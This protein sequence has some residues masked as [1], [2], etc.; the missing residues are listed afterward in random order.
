MAYYDDSYRSKLQREQRARYYTPSSKIKE[1]RVASVDVHFDGEAMVLTFPADMQRKQLI[2]TLQFLCTHAPKVDSTGLPSLLELTSSERLH[3]SADGRQCLHVSRREYA[4]I[5]AA[6]LPLYIEPTSKNI[7]REHGYKPTA[8][9]P[10]LMRYNMTRSH[11]AQVDRWRQWAFVR[12]LA[13]LTN[14]T[15]SGAPLLDYEGDIRRASEHYFVVYTMLPRVLDIMFKY[16]G[17]ATARFVHILQTTTIVYDAMAAFLMPRRLGYINH[18]LIDEVMNIVELDPS[19][20]ARNNVFVTEL[21]KLATYVSTLDEHS[22]VRIKVEHDDAR[23]DVNFNM[24]HTTMYFAVCE[25]QLDNHV[26]MAMLCSL[27]VAKRSNKSLYRFL[28]DIPT[29]CQFNR[30]AQ[31][32]FNRA[33]QGWPACDHNKVVKDVLHEVVTTTR[34]DSI[35]G[36][37][38][39]AP[40]LSRPH[41]PLRK[42][43]EECQTPTYASYTSLVKAEE[44]TIMDDRIVVRTPLEALYLYVSSFDRSLTV[45]FAEEMEVWDLLDNR[46][47]CSDHLL[48]LTMNGHYLDRSFFHL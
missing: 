44:E 12:A 11:D 35:L 17:G 43:R 39:E 4:I 14:A 3:E 9:H 16:Y 5:T 32:L 45:P 23:C 38:G 40:K 10:I 25:Q 47:L 15:V 28:D 8:W 26:A 31:D 29:P 46:I 37:T 6:L 33:T 13:A 41:F 18:R 1:W 24:L 48:P 2:E 34:Y 21:R 20:G 19:F 7:K 36:M 22:R 30:R 42:M 27:S